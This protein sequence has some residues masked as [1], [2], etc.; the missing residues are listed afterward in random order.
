MAKEL[1]ILNGNLFY[2]LRSIKNRKKYCKKITIDFFFIMICDCKSKYILYIY[3]IYFYNIFILI[4]S[5]Y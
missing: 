4:M 1:Y 2:I 3:Y 5:L